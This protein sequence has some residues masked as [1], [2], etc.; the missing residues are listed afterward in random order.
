MPYPTP[1]IGYGTF[2]A[3]KNPLHLVCSLLTT[4]YL[5]KSGRGTG[6]MTPA[7]LRKTKGGKSRSAA[8]LADKVAFEPHAP[9]LPAG[10]FVFVSKPLRRHLRAKP[11]RRLHA[12]PPRRQ[13]APACA[14]TRQSN[15]NNTLWTDAHL[16]K[17]EPLR[18]KTRA[19]SGV[20]TSSAPLGGDGGRTAPGGEPRGSYNV[21]T[22]VRP[23]EG[24][25][26]AY[27]IHI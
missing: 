7:N 17:A 13:Q 3:C 12:M 2:W 20:G 4:E 15:R 18:L 16:Q 1:S 19:T 21:S 8:A 23:F 22:V 10:A 27:R 14:L 11:A 9:A 26:H 5:I 25:Y 6:P 24:G